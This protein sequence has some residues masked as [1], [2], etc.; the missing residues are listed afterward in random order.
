MSRPT[1][2]RLTAGIVLLTVLCLALPAAA[3]PVHPQAPKAPAISLLDQ[4]LGWI[5]SFLPGQP[6]VD[7]SPAEKTIGV[8]TLPGG[9][10]G[11][12]LGSALDN[13]DRGAM[14]DPNG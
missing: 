1:V 2:R 14:I 12:S 10:D 7:K 3:A 6:S 11:A 4:F 9:T 8:G 5:G 13:S